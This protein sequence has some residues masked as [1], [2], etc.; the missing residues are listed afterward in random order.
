M[1]VNNW[2]TRREMLTPDKV[3]LIDTLNGG[4]SIT[5]REWNRQANRTANFLRE[6]LHIQKGDRVAVLAMNSVEY[7]DLWFACG[8][9]GAIIQLLNWRLTPHELIGLLEDATPRVLVYSR[10]F[11]EQVEAV[12]PH[13]P[14]LEYFVTMD[15]ALQPGDVLFFERDTFSEAE[16]PTVELEWDD[17]WAI[18][19]TGGTTG[20]PKGAIL[21]HRSVT[22]NSI[23]TVT[24]W[25]L[26][27]MTSPCCNYRC[28]TPAASM[29][30]P[31][32]WC[33][34]VVRQLSARVLILTRPLI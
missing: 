6:R 25:G 31:P 28:S 16:P 27:L 13:A 8:K 23:N 10:E 24:G 18:C 22:A 19:Y 1:Y 9:I 30:S 26:T 29:F 34:L 21:T 15:E 7:L 11:A 12:R 2:L 14:S 32:R 20:L 33:T 3:A 17:A 5:Y 4:A